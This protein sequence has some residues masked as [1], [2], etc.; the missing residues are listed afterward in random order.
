MLSTS[1]RA[2]GASGGL[3]PGGE[4]S[5]LWLLEGRGARGEGA[6]EEAGAVA[7]V[8]KDEAWGKYGRDRQA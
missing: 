2:L 6:S 1:L 3:R 7:R 8:G 4:Q 5:G